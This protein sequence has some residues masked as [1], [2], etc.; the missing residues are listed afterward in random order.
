MNVDLDK[1]KDNHFILTDPR[2]L[3]KLSNYSCSDRICYQSVELKKSV[4]FRKNYKM[5]ITFNQ[6]NEKNIFSTQAEIH[7]IFDYPQL[8]QKPPVF[9][10]QEHIFY[11]YENI[12]ADATIRNASI[13]VYEDE[14]LSTYNSG[15]YLEIFDDEN[16]F[17]K[18]TFEIEPNFGMGFL[19]S[20]LKLKP[21]KQLD[22]ETGPNIFNFKVRI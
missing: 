9:L 15:F 19:V 4:P 10:L 17:V 8:A 20:F 16:S 1:F 11:I 12:S 5:N 21:N 3:F 7:A 22:H 14:P 6:Q 2:N 18:D 13:A